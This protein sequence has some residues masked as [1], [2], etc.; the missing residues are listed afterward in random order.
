M[1]LRPSYF[2]FTE[3]SAEVDITCVLCDGQGCRVCKQTGWLE[4]AGCGMV[5][6]NVF[7]ACG[8]DAERYTGCAFGVG[9]ERL[10]MLR[11]GVNDLRLFFENDLRFLAQ[12]A[13]L[14]R[15]YAMKLPLSWLRDW[16]DVPWKDRELADRL[17]MLGFEVEAHRSR[18]AALQRRRGRA[19]SSSAEPHPQADKLRVCTVDDGRSRQR[20]ALQIVCGG[21]NARAGLRTALATCR[22]ATAGR[23]SSSAPR[24]CAAWNRRAC[25][26]RRASWA[27]ARRREGILELPADAPLGAI[28]RDYLELDDVVL[29]VN[30]TPNRG[31]AMSVLGIAREVAALRAARR[32][33]RSRSLTWQPAA[34]EATS[35]SRC[36]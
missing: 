17:T 26:A 16:V 12:F 24:S 23:R 14:S 28:L 29:E 22:R 8:I 3:P 6:P 27:W 35:D 31:D 1:R 18:G 5:H 30:V 32:C 19:R 10:A 4:I 9:I 11:Y 25:C 34:A 13:G 33:A 7:E 21:A 2:P 20:G 15:A 36:S